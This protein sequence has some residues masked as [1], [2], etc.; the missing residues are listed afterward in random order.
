[1][2]TVGKQF[3]GGEAVAQFHSSTADSFRVNCKIHSWSVNIMLVAVALQAETLGCSD[4][5][6]IRN[7]SLSVLYDFE[8]AIHSLY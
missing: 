3:G 8:T 6:G 1:L 4:C 7:K 5:T 2:F